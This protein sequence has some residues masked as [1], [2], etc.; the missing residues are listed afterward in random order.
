MARVTIDTRPIRDL[1]GDKVLSASNYE[2]LLEAR[3]R[4]P[5]VPVTLKHT[6]DFVFVRYIG[7]PEMEVNHPFLEEWAVYL[8]EQIKAGSDVFM[9]CHSPDNLIAP[10][11]CR[12]LYSRV[13][14]QTDLAPLPWDLIRQAKPGQLSLF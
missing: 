6:A 4:K 14:T 2:S 5:N 1:K 10:S 8:S 11:I 13:R 7:H 12:E 9:F 3:E